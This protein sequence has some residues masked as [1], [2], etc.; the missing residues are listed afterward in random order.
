M[1]TNDNKDLSILIV[2]DEPLISIFI[3]RVVKSQGFHNITICYDSQKAI[4]IINTKKPQLIFMDINIKGSL[5][6]I[7][8]IRK[9]TKYHPIVYYISAY[10]DDDI[11]SEALSTNPYNYLVKPIKEE[12][13]KIALQ[14]SNKP[15]KHITPQESHNN[16]INFDDNIYYSHSQKELFKDERTLSLSSIEKKLINLFIL[17]MNSNLSIEMIRNTIWQDNS[18]EDVSI[19]GRISVLRKKVPQ[20]KIETNFGRGY[21]LIYPKHSQ[22]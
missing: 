7:S 21:M 5:D 2:D 6:G 13:I 16:T 12:D 4:E 1:Y 14:L 15:K 8:V 11:I 9:V 19:R 17:N 18:I 20:L 22:L 10:N 3:K